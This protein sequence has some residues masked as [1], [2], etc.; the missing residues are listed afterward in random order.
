MI[1][2]AQVVR[3]N[4][5]RRTV[6][7]VFLDTREPVREALVMGKAS[8]IGGSWDVPDVAKPVSGQAT[9]TV[10]PATPS[11]VAVVAAMDGHP[12][13]LGFV[14]AQGNQVAVTPANLEIDRHPS[15]V[16]QTIEADGSIQTIHPGGVTLRI[17]TP[18]L[19]NLATVAADQNWH[20]PAGTPPTVTLI[21]P[22]ATM[23]I[24]PAT[25]NITVVSQGDVSVTAKDAIVNASSN[26]TVTA[27]A[28]A[29]VTAPEVLLGS[30]TA[31]MKRVVVDG[32]PTAKGDTV[33]AQQNTH[34]FAL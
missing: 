3:V 19:L 25:G 5:A 17:G 27:G 18:A 12:V 32:D 10:P 20:V 23:V 29:Q 1:R 7:L 34:V 22:K 8:N 30:A 14:P 15:G 21:T 9:G 33:I 26:V 6:D 2:L 11:M 16:V 28:V 4:Q 13:V 31:G 24:D